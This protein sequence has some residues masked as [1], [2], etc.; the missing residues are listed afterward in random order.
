VAQVDGLPL[1]PLLVHA[2]VVLIPLVAIG[3]VLVLARPSLRR[4]LA[5]VVAVL[6]IAAAASAS[7]AVWSGAELGEALGRGVE[8]D[9]HQGWGEWTRTAAI[10]VA[11]GAV[12]F[13]IVDRWLDRRAVAGSIGVVTTG[14]AVTA[15]AIVAIAGHSG[16]SLAWQDRVPVTSSDAPVGA[17]PAVGLPGVDLV[18]GEWAIV[19]ST[20]E[21]PPG[22]TAF[23]FHNRGTVPH[24]IRIR[25][26]G[27]GTRLEWRSERVEPGGWGVLV[28]DLPPGTYDLDCP[29]ED[30][31]GEHDALG[32]ELR[33]DVSEHAEAL[34]VL[35]PVAGT[36]PGAA[37]EG[38]GDTTHP[39][40][41]TD[42]HEQTV[43]IRGFTFDPEVVRAPV[44][45]EMAWTND[46][47]APHTATG[48]AFDT[49]RLDQG[50]TGRV[51][52]REP[53][54]Y[55]YRC[56]LHPAMRGTVVVSP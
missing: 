41:G 38:P 9:H 34:S 25:S 12:A 53:G 15:T 37:P 20:T 11:V 42:A 40:D 1:H 50:A 24:A 18:L 14:L 47:P 10:V 36:G 32:M 31:A 7:A 21:V 45:A 16:A 2:P 48:T 8:L 55:D 43:V 28:A 17:V 13:T 33:L 23:R 3:L 39:A 27:P 4:Q 5:P 29:I 46:D 54:T 51:V 44:G 35:P 19:S 26:S 52:F 6:A 30:A 22:S 56:T 49:G